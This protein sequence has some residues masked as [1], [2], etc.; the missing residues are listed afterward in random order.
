[1][2]LPALAS[3][4]ERAKKIGCVNNLR[5]VGLGMI[6][7]AGDSNDMLLPARNAGSAA[8]P[9]FV[10]IAMNDPQESADCGAWQA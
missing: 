6:M 10:Q 2:L 7:Y 1:M 4:K 5:Q 9:A 8:V 3:A